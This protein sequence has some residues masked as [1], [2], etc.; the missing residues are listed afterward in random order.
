[1]GNWSL[2]IRNPRNGWRSLDDYNV[3]KYEDYYVLWVENEQYMDALP[4]Y[5]VGYTL[6]EFNRYIY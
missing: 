1:M 6:L 4:K 2:Q 3:D 5:L